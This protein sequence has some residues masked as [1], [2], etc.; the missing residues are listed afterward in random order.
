MTS[1]ELLIRGLIAGLIIAAPVGPI[2]VL[3][4]SRTLT[5]GRASGLLS[6]LGAAA[7]DTFYGCIAGFSITFVIQFLIR[8]EF[9]ICLIGGIL[10]VIIG[11]SYYRKRPQALSKDARDESDHSD[12]VSTFLLTL[13]NP[14]TVLSFL[15]VL[16]GLGMSQGR[17]S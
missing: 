17:V 3:C 15:A 12:F 7:A 9:W 5:K 14:T 16:T 2:N 4:I 8:E 10:L 6:G 11:I 13:T 1:V